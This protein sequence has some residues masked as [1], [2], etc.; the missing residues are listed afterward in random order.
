MSFSQQYI[1]A[2]FRNSTEILIVKSR[3]KCQVAVEITKRVLQL[4]GC[5]LGWAARMPITLPVCL[6]NPMF[7]FRSN[8]KVQAAKTS[9]IHKLI[10]PHLQLHKDFTTH[11]QDARSLHRV[12]KSSNHV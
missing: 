8:P 4:F 12:S 1:L 10:T 7:S 2:P 5:V 6:P 3:I 11:A 9:S